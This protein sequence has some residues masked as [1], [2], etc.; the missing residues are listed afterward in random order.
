MRVRAAVLAACA[1]L[2]CGCGSAN[3]SVLLTSNGQG[4]TQTSGFDPNGPWVLD[5]KW[6]CSS[7]LLR[8]KSLQPGFTWN[9]LNRDDKTLTAENPHGQSKGVKGSGTARYSMGGAFSIDITSACDWV[10]QVT[11]A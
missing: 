7:V 8:N 3:D 2:F 6:D 1:V 10:V 9:T 5:Y 4:P 11:T